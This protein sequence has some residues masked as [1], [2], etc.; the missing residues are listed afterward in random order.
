ML[1]GI[2]AFVGFEAALVAAGETRNPRRDVPF[3]V[4]MSLL[5]VLILYAGVQIVCIAC[6]AVVGD[7]HGSVR[8]CSRRAVGTGGRAGDY[9]SARS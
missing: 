1:L 2:F 9:A 3:A 8:R 7:E 4:A 5:I 6:R